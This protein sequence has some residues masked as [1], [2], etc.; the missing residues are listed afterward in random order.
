[1]ANENDTLSNMDKEEKKRLEEREQER[2]ASAKLGEK[3]MKIPKSIFGWLLGL[4]ALF[5]IAPFVPF[6]SEPA[7]LW[8]FLSV[9]F[10][11][12]AIAFFMTQLKTVPASNPTSKAVVTYW[13]KRYAHVLDEGD[14]F[15]AN[16]LPFRIDF[17]VVSIENQNLDFVYTH[18]RCKDE[19]APGTDDEVGKERAGGS[20]EVEVSVTFV[21]DTENLI[22]HITAGGISRS[23]NKNPETKTLIHDIIHDMLGEAV[24]QEGRNRTWERMTF[25]QKALIGIILEKL[26]GKKIPGMPEKWTDF[27]EDGKEAGRLRTYLEKTLVNG[28]SDIHDLGIKIKRINVVRAEPDGPLAEAANLSAIEKQER[29]AELVQT[30]ATIEQGE[31]YVKASKDNDGNPTI[32]LGEGLRVSRLER[33]KNSSEVHVDSSGSPLLDAA[34]LFTR[35]PSTKND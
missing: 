7:W 14:W 21:A 4:G 19:S 6:V 20:V 33:D 15:M 13:G 3:I 18:I 31:L 11:G 9:I 24:R 1:M 22:K 10:F 34:A 12:N 16:F 28:V 2:E 32:T 35:S 29:I 30:E 26:I 27:N 23:E 5:L 25:S 17:I 8:I